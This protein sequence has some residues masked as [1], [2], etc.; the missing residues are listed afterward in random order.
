MAKRPEHEMEL[1]L[2]QWRKRMYHEDFSEM[3]DAEQAKEIGVAV[4]TIG[5]WHKTQT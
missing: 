2:E 1:A 4:G 5:K 3:T